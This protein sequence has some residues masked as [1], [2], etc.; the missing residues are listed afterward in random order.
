M[1]GEYMQQ[2]TSLNIFGTWKGIELEMCFAGTALAVEMF[3]PFF[4]A[5][6]LHFPFWEH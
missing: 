6:K 4:Q 2:S 1:R 3:S 5:A